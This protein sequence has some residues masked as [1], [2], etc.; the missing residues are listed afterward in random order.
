MTTNVDVREQL[1]CIQFE[2]TQRF[3][4]SKYWWFKFHIITL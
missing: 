1:L 4:S 2:G 3:V